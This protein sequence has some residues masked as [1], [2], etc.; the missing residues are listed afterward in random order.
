MQKMARIAEE[1]A[2]NNEMIFNVNKCAYLGS[3]N[4]GP[5]MNNGLIPKQ[6]RTKYLGMIFNAQ[7]LDTVASA[8]ERANKANYR[9]LCSDE[10]KVSL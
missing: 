1:W 9:A 10:I 6:Q 5:E 8:G 2:N 3:A 7:G 4:N